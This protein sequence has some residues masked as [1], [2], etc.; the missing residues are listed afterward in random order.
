M[1]DEIADEGPLL[2][3]FTLHRDGVTMANTYTVPSE[4]TKYRGLHVATQSQIERI[5]IRDLLR[6]EALIERNTTLT[7]F[8][9]DDVTSTVVARFS[10][11]RKEEEVVEAKYLVDSEGASSRIREMI[12]VPLGGLATDCFF[13]IID[14]GSKQTIR[15]YL[16]LGMCQQPSKIHGY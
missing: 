5:Y 13:A 12:G 14:C 11:N 6:H 4:T 1:G 9:V 10:S 8:D 2:N 16:T 7:S 15:I 3:R